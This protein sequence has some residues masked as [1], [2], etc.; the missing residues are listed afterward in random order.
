[1]LKKSFGAL[2]LSIV[3]CFAMLWICS[4]RERAAVS[5]TGSI[6]PTVERQI[7]VLDP[8]HGGMDGG[9]ISINGN[10][11]KNINLSISNGLKDM[12]TVFGMDV[13]CTRTEDK[14]IHDDGTEGAGAQ[15]RSD[16]KNRL[17]LFNKYQNAIAVSI[18]QNQ[19]TDEKFSGAQMFYS[20][21]NAAG[22][23]LAEC[24]QKQFVTFLQPNNTRET[25][26]V[27]DELYLLDNTSCPSIMAECGFLSN[28]S[29]AD[30][31]ENGEYQKKV[32]FTLMSG[33][34]EFMGQNPQEQP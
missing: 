2:T 20:K 10:P 31:L 18:H 16:M 28:K 1:M 26:G 19:F 7:I 34:F 17:A 4:G 27:G 6:K 23:Q 22:K 3:F 12:L 15:K 29:E 8:G 5:T 33:I 30:N 32:S 21:K 14:S 11:E 24:M 13:K 9:C 25:K